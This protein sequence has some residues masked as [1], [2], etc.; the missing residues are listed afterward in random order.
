MSNYL[1][2]KYGT[3]MTRM[4][5]M[6]AD[7]HKVFADKKIMFNHKNLSKPSVKAVSLD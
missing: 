2:A 5:M 7:K 1:P 6:N 4:N 3:Q